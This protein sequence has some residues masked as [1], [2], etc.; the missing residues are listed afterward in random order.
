MVNGEYRRPPVSLPDHS[1]EVITGTGRAWVSAKVIRFPSAS[2]AR[3]ASRVPVRRS[4]A[5][6]PS[7]ASRPLVVPDSARIASAAWVSLASEGRPRAT[8]DTTVPFTP[9]R[10]ST[11]ASGSVVTP[12]VVRPSCSTSGP[13]AAIFSAS[14]G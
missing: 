9:A 1:G 3:S 6:K 11:S 2:A 7:T 5:W 13:S 8:P 4:R 10:Y 14:F 12:L